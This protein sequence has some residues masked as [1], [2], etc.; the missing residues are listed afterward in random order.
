MTN[1]SWIYVLNS[2]AKGKVKLEHDPMGWEEQRVSVTRSPTYYGLFREVSTSLKF[3][4]DGKDYIQEVYETLGID[5]KVFISIYE[6]V[7]NI[8][9]YLRFYVG[10]IDLSTYSFEETFIECDISDSDFN[11]KVMSRDDV[12][13]NMED[14]TSIG[15]IDLT[16]NN[17][18]QVNLTSRQTSLK[19][20]YV[21]DDAIDVMFSD[22]GPQ[23]RN[24]ITLPMTL[25]ANSIGEGLLAQTPYGNVDTQT[26]LFRLPTTVDASVTVTTHVKGNLHN[27]VN[28][29]NNFYFALMLYSEGIGLTPGQWDQ[30][31]LLDFNAN[32]DGG[33][34]FEFES[35]EKNMFAPANNGEISFVVFSSGAEQFSVRFSEIDLTIE[36]NELRPNTNA[37]GHL[38]HEVGERLC[39]S[40]TDT[41][42]N[43]KSDLLGRIDL[44]YAVDGKASLQTLHTGKQ[45]RNI[46]D[47]KLTISLKDLFAS[48]NAQRNIGIGIEYNELSQPI[49]RLE[50]KKHFFSGDVISTIYS[51]K[52]VRKKVARDWIYNEIEVGYSK[53]EYE[54]IDGLEEQN[55]KFKWTTR[56]ETIKNKLDLVSKIRADGYGIEFA[57]RKQYKEYPT[58]DTKYD[59]DLFTVVVFKSGSEYKNKTNNG[60]DVVENIFSPDT[61]YNLDITPGRMLRNSG[62]LI[63]SGLEHNLSTPAKF[64]YAEQKQNLV[65]QQT[66]GELI[67]ENADID[68]NTLSSPLWLPEI[69][70]FESVLGRDQLDNII[71]NSNGLIKFSTT[72]ESRTTKFYYGWLIEIDSESDSNEATW[73]ILR[74]NLSSSDLVLNDPGGQPEPGVPATDPPEVYGFEYQLELTLEG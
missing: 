23:G 65:S 24:G 38:L 13:I 66:G 64:H 28:A 60:Y 27:S 43:F 45:L 19:G 73:Q 21:N 50:E 40:I 42:G 51:V 47:S 8:D 36:V 3:V 69:Y 71:R 53:A 26:S 61:A 37:P 59:N 10:L 17:P 31:S 55:N 34:D 67:D 44:G 32:I 33:Y 56:I 52:N 39:D 7:S 9:K 16:A 20:I 58:E 2:D 25:T 30:F 74:A 11:R 6:Y 35:E 14:L 63:R 49:L 62:M 1:K 18:I 4:K 46:P 29:S 70:T 54:E 5:A 22:V 57:R 41:T 48:L 12:G 15:G 68:I 72:T